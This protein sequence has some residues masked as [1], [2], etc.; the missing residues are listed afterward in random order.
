[1]LTKPLS[2]PL[3]THDCSMMMEITITAKRSIVF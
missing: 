2:A 1:M 3:N